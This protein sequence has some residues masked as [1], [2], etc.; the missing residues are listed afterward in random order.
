MADRHL[1]L[2]YTYN[3][4][5]ELIENNLTRAFIVFLSILSGEVRHNILTRLLKRAHETTKNAINIENLDFREARFALQSNIDRYIPKNSSRKLLLTI[6][7]EPL[8][9]S[10]TI[11]ATGTE[12]AAEIENDGYF[13]SVPDAW[14]Y[15]DAQTYCIL[16]EAKVGS[17]PLDIGQLKAHAM[18]WFGSSLQNLVACNSLGSITWIEVLEILRGTISYVDSSGGRF[19]AHMM[20]FISYYGYRLFDGIDFGDLCMPPDWIIG[21]LLLRKSRALDL[22]FHHLESPPD[23]MLMYCS[24]DSR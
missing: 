6:S 18:D 5:T 19:I 24:L 22:N 11:A 16:L 15:D 10:F 9:P 23:F 13:T 12:A 4:D 17:Y 8:D 21:N 7:T 20:E 2:F 3:R 1:N 14:V